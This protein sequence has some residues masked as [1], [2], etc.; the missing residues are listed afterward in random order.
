MKHNIDY[1]RQ[2]VDV[3]DLVAVYPW[4]DEP[5]VGEVERVKT[6]KYKRISYTVKGWEKQVMA[7]ELFPGPLQ[8]KLK[9]P[10]RERAK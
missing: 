1:K 9:I 5:F 2:W 6:N 8:E 10:Y 7:E 4:R 3:G